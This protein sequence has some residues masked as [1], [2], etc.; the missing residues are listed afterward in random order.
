MSGRFC[1]QRVSPGSGLLDP[2]VV[3]ALVGLL[4]NDH[5]LKAASAGTPWT[6]LTG[7]LSDV[8][9]V[10]FLPVLIVAGIEIVAGWR[11]RFCGPSQRLALVVAIGVG[12]TFALMKS[13][14]VVGDVYA[15]ALGVLQW[16]LRATAALLQ[17]AAVPSAVAVNH[18]VDPTDTI[19]VPAAAWVVLQARVRAAS[20]AINGATKASNS[21]R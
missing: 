15:F 8:C 2:V 16:P 5:V 4:L 20:W 14:A 13:V 11:G 6:L 7:K 1:T 17:S 10:L 3:V 18:V 21:G 19:A 12:V 9:G